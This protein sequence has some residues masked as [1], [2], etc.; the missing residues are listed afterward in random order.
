GPTG[1]A[2]G[3]IHNLPN[4][5]A[6]SVPEVIH[7]FV[8]GLKSFERKNVRLCEIKHMDV[9]ADAGS[10]HGVVIGTEDGD[11]GTRSGSNLKDEW[12]EVSLRIVSLAQ[13]IR[14]A[15]G[16]EVAKAGVVQMMNSV[17]PVQHSLDQELRFAVGVGRLQL[18]VLLDGSSLGL[19]VEGGGRGE[20]ESFHSGAE[21][22]F[23]EI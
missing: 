2:R 22:G 3:D 13:F 20:D 23:E 4:T 10:V 12:N 16:V 17:K 9:V 5:E 21:H 7:Q 11:A 19:A 6:T 1:H 8:A 18:V 15:S 14:G